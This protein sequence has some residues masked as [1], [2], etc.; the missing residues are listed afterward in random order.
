[1]ENNTCPA[2]KMLS[3]RE[4]AEILNI[5]KVGVYRLTEQRK[6]RF[7]KIMGSIRFTREDVMEFLKNNRFETIERK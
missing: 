4:L 6:L 5:S 7:Y 3:T 1:M 2:P